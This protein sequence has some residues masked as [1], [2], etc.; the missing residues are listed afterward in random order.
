MRSLN[1]TEA[2]LLND[3]VAEFGTAGVMLQIAR[4]RD[5]QAESF[6][7]E[8]QM[9]NADSAVE[10]R[11]CRENARQIR[12]MAEKLGAVDDAFESSG[13]IPATGDD[14][15]RTA[16]ARPV[17]D[18]RSAS[19]YAGQICRQAIARMRHWHNAT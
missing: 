15:D 3:L 12:A 14:G 6:E 2:E 18:G 8:A 10:A 19:A 9:G 7:M 5:D 16:S 17:G 1:V 13:I 4:L 11:L